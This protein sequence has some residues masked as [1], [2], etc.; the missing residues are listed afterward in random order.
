MASATITSPVEHDGKLLQPG[1]KLKASAA[2]IDA[3]VA[4]GVAEIDGK[5][6]T[7]SAPAPAAVPSAEDGTSQA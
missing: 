6:V 5:P 4:A 3:L 2:A 1:D 7:A